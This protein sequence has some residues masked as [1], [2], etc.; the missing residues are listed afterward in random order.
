MCLDPLANLEEIVLD[1][2]LIALWDNQKNRVGR[3][4]GI[5]LYFG[6]RLEMYLSQEG[7]NYMNGIKV[8]VQEGGRAVG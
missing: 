4:V 7:V 6:W 2:L 8:L 1:S 5:L 3:E